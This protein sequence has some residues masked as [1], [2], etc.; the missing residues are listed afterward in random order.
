MKTIQPEK[1]IL[2]GKEEIILSPD[3]YINPEDG[4]VYC[5]K[6]H[7]RKRYGCIHQYFLLPKRALLPVCVKRKRYKNKKR[8]S[9]TERMKT[10][11]NDFISLLAFRKD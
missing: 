9:V 11:K 4:L 6:C 10:R 2:S 1:E 5:S 7:T 3:E 8:K